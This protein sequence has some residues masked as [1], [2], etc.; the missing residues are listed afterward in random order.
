MSKV[1]NIKHRALPVVPVR[2]VSK[3][4]NTNIFKI[5]IAR[6]PFLRPIMIRITCFRPSFPG[7]PPKPMNEHKVDQGLGRGEKQIESKW[8]FNVFYGLFLWYLTSARNLRTRI[9]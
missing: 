4:M 1:T 9:Q 2:V 5:C 6:K 3:S 7:S 8:P